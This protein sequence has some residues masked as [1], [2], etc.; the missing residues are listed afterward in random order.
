MAIS[1]NQWTALGVVAY[2]PVLKKL[3]EDR[4]AARTVIISESSGEKTQIPV[5]AYNKKAHVLCAL[6]HKGSTIFA[7]G[8]LCTNI[9]LTSRQAKTLVM[10]NFKI[11][12]FD[13]LIR[14]PIKVDDI[15]YVDIA[16]KYDPE[17]FME[18]E[19]DVE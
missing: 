17:Y 6:A 19:E 11:T 1:S 7:K 2:E 15:D 5:V 16:A 8:V 4:V 18:V 3:S 12:D 14:E 13:V 9:E 10:I